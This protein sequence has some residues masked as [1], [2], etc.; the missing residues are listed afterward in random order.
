MAGLDLKMGGRLQDLRKCVEIRTSSSCAYP[1]NV[2]F[3]AFREDAARRNQNKGAIKR[4]PERVLTS[5][6]RAWLL[7]GELS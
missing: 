6:L 7:F 1:F 2:I 5:L 3:R 4:I